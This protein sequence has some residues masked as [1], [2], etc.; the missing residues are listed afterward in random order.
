L[1]NLFKR[2]RGNTDYDANFFDSH[3]EEV[4]KHLEDVPG[5][6]RK[7]VLSALVVLTGEGKA[8]DAYREQMVKDIGSYNEALKD[9]QRT[10]SQRENWVSRDQVAPTGVP[11]A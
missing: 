10:P 1:R 8:T 7:S 9:Q 5:A 6:K 4:L 11:T 2:L 3:H